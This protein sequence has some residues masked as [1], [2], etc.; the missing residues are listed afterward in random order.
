LIDA[1]FPSGTL[2]AVLGPNGSGK[3]TLLRLL[4]GVLRPTSGKVL[5]G[6]APLLSI[7]APV[8]AG[9]IAYIPQVPR[10]IEPFSVRQ[11]VG[12]GRFARP[13][14]GAAIEGAIARVGIADRAS[15]PFGVL[16][17][18][19]QQ[20]VTLAR[21]LAQL[22]GAGDEPGALRQVILADEPTGAM[23]PKHAM[24]AMLILREQCAL[25]RAAVVVMHDVNMAVRYA[26]RALVLGPDGRVAGSGRADETL[27]PELL[28]KVFEVGFDRVPTGAGGWL[29]VKEGGRPAGRPA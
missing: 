19:Q 26:D 7:S 6:H 1:E 21:V 12:F 10:L 15:E 20:R 9:L 27:T 14:D 18:G 5:L 22:G 16:S 17:A 28:E 3:S 29:I 11:V 8:R 4:L 23:D 2:T 25:G 13:A 24:E